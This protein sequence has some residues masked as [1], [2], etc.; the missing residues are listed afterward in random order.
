M[1]YRVFRLCP[2]TL[3][4]LLKIAKVIHVV[5]R[6]RRRRRKQKSRYYNGIS[7]MINSHVVVTELECAK[8]RG[9]RQG[10]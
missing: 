2:S 9:E 1:T 6:E 4:G 8:G 10:Y 5:H 3:Y 7:S